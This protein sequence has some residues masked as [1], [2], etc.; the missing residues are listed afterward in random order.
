MVQ[1][2]LETLKI[3]EDE[4]KYYKNKVF[5]AC[6]AVSLGVKKFKECFGT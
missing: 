5:Y 1:K 6:Q 4:E 2:A 3:S